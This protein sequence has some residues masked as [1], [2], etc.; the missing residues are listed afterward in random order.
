MVDLTKKISISQLNDR[1]PLSGDEVIVYNADAAIGNRAA[2][3][4]LAQAVSLIA[5]S[6]CQVSITHPSPDYSVS[7]TG[8]GDNRLNP[9]NGGYVSVLNGYAQVL[10]SGT[11]FTTNADGR[12]T[13]NAA[14]VVDVTAYV[15]VFHSS[16]NSSVGAVVSVERNGTTTYSPRAVHSKATN[17]GDIGNISGGGVLD[18]QAGDILGIALASDN[19]GN[20]TIASS[21]VVFRMYT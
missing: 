19:T 14:G 10:N 11:R 16:N 1:S 21:S 20:I 18:A 17:A 6:I 12:V 13:V 9:A 8:T 5:P 4:P 15:D 2:R 3:V 7:V